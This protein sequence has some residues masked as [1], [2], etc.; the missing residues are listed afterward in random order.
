MS[1][2]DRE[3]KEWVLGE[4]WTTPLEKCM[5]HQILATL[6]YVEVLNRLLAEAC[7]NSSGAAGWK[8]SAWFMQRLGLAERRFEEAS[9][10]HP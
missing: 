7:A 8:P 10:E 5:A 2:T 9:G 4:P 1:K 6:Q 3:I